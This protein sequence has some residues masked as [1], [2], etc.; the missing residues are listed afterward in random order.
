MEE[1]ELEYGEIIDGKYYKVR[2]LY[3]QINKEE[4]HNKY[5]KSKS[6]ERRENG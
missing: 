1:Y 4:F 6:Y 5:C 2:T 3:K